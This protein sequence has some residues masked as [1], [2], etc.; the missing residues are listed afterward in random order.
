MSFLNNKSSYPKSY[1]SPNLNEPPNFVVIGSS[2]VF[3]LLLIIIVYYIVT[4]RNSTMRSGNSSQLMRNDILKKGDGSTTPTAIPVPPKPTEIPIR[5]V[6]NKNIKQVFNIKENI[7][8]L[9]DAPAV[10]GTLGADLASVNQLIDAHKNGAD[11]CNVGWTKDGLAAYPIQYSTWQTLQD[12]D[13]NKRDICGKPG[14]NLAR[15]DPNLLYGVN[16]YGVKPE[17][18]GNEKVKGPIISD[19][20]AALDAKIAELKKQLSSIGVASFNNDQWSQ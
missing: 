4:T 13:P 16:C 9:Q 8:T 19:K 5:T 20:Q 1:P 3:G 2:A 18:K 12:N 17:P 11:W 15:N 10:C 14:I 6:S 7:Y